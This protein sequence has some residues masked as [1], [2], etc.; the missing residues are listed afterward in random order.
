[1]LLSA[2][3]YFWL[4]LHTVV[5]GPLSPKEALLRI[6]RWL[7]SGHAQEVEVELTQ[8]YQFA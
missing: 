5:S 8:Q 4:Y 3:I 2:R 7:N 1:M 6:R